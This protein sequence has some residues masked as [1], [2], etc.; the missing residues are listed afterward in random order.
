[1]SPVPKSKQKQYGIII[2]ANINR[3]KSAEEAKRIAEKWL[4]DKKKR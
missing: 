3:G 2:G 1:M 4:R